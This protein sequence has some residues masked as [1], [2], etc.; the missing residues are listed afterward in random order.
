M[1]E[2]VFKKISL[3]GYLP[4]DKGSK[5]WFRENISLVNAIMAG[6]ILGLTWLSERF[7]VIPLWLVIPSYS[8]VFGLAGYPIARHAIAALRMRRFD[9]DL[10]MILGAAGAAA[11]GDF[12]EGGLLLF[13]FSLGHALEDK[14]L[15]RARK[16]IR[17]LGELMPR[18]ALVKRGGEDVLVPTEHI[19]L[20]D[21]VVVRP[22]ERIPMDGTVLNGN[23]SVNQAPI[24]GESLPVEKMEGSVVFAGAING[25]GV[26]DI[27]VE[28]LAKDSTLAKI[29][30]LVEQAQNQISPSQQL[31]QRFSKIFVPSVLT[32]TLLLMFI[33]QLWGEDFSSSFYRSL[34]FL[35]AVSPCALAIGTPAAILAGVAQAARN[36]VLV[37]GGLHLENL[38]LLKV[39]VFDKTGTLTEGL[40]RVSSIHPARDWH[41][42]EV[43]SLAAG[44]E[45]NSLHPLARAVIDEANMREIAIP[46]ADEVQML[47]GLGVTGSL[48]GKSVFVGNERLLKQVR[49]E[50]DKGWSQPKINS[51]AGGGSVFWVATQGRVVG[52]IT[53]SDNVRS[54]SKQVIE[55]LRQ[56][57]VQKMHI[58]SGDSHSATQKIA[59]QVGA[60]E[61]SADLMPEDKF[62]AVKSLK[63]SNDS[64][65]MVGDGIND[66]PAL[67]AA[68]VGIAI[69]GAGTDVALEAA[70]VA[71]MAA[72]LEKLPFA[73]GLGRATRRII[74]QN[75]AI[76]MTVIVVLGVIALGGWAGIGPVVLFHEG[77]TLLVVM[78][79]L[80]LLRFSNPGNDY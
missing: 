4:R 72:S 19:V 36:G 8:L 60:D 12:A 67:A 7:L 55:Q 80:R 58:L 30:S 24:T 31:V 62:S 53:F 79:A 52:M 66:A 22:G 38:G 51:E 32:S 21:I 70:D 33:P 46:E 54:E 49:V 11:L 42:N 65:G 44:L 13:L 26:I 28:K 17:A 34:V 25:E 57:G 47:A 29:V 27:K 16:A 77:S 18:Q 63:T 37:K 2:T 1:A 73:I 56:L 48:N 45:K 75:L 39:I 9:T 64:V 5:S 74:I 50:I 59:T 41:E 69:G 78:N 43:L 71:L 23:S 14:V 35:I 40:P 3:L 76:A 6:V 10:L 20:D 68:D 15:D 61:F